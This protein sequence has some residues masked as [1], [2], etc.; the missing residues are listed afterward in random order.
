MLVTP[1][2]RSGACL[3]AAASR[4][5]AGFQSPATSEGCEDALGGR[6]RLVRQCVSKQGSYVLCPRSDRRAAGGAT[7]GRGRTSLNTRQMLE[8]CPGHNQRT[9][10]RYGACLSRA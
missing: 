6:G 7:P 9:R 10:G 2:T 3:N 8:V 1:D 4:P 5:R